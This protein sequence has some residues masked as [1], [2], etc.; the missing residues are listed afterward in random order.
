MAP[1]FVY[2]AEAVDGEV[3]RETI[4]GGETLVEFPG[5]GG[6]SRTVSSGDGGG[7]SA[8]P[9]PGGGS[10]VHALSSRRAAREARRGS[11]DM[12][13]QGEG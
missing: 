7:A 3:V 13:L 10:T 1:A 11:A 2:E 6:G 9:G 12:V 5:E 4:V 8:S